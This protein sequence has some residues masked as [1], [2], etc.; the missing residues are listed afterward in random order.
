VTFDPGLNRGPIWSPDGR[1]IAFSAARE[2]TETIHW[3]M[4]DGSGRSERLVEGEDLRV[5]SDFSPDGKSILFNQPATPP[6][7]LGMVNVEG[8]RKPRLLLHEKFSE[9]NGALS[10]DG[11]WLA[12]ES[13]ESGRDEIYVRPFPNV[14]S[15]RSQVSTG[16]GT[17]PLWSKDGREL[18]YY[19]QPGIVLSARITPGPTFAAAAPAVI[20]KG[21]YLSP[22]TGRTY[23]VAPDGQRFLMVK[24]APRAG[25]GP[26]P[27]QLVVVQN[28]L[29]ELKRLV[30][31]N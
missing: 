20:F 31:V 26:P 21:T 11:R 19:L 12:Y 9:H 8:D 22:Q 24:A 15:G 30:P 4:A 17:R 23:D 13:D 2:G 10:P 28:W 14:D 5:P 1:R 7:D 25:D 6:Y 16:G 3:Q 27:P 29:D 18:F